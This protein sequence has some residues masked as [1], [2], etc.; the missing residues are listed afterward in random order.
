MACVSL[1]NK[2]YMYVY[3]INGWSADKISK[4]LCSFNG[5]KNLCLIHSN[6]KNH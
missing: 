4:F 6:Y 1:N 5:S 2:K 3:D